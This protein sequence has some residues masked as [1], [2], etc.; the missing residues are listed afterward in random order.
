MEWLK[1]RRQ[2]GAK[3]AACEATRSRN[4]SKRNELERDSGKGLDDDAS[5]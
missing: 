2:T 1:L 4:S 5:E 3:S